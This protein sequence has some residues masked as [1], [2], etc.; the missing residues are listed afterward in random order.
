MFSLQ[1]WADLK[2]NLEATVVEQHVGGGRCQKV[3]EDM[4]EASSHGALLVR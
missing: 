3:S 4:G 1:V 2:R